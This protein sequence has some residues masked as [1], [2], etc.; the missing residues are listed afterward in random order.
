MD[1]KNIK[2]ISLEELKNQLVEMGEQQYR[3]GQVFRWLYKKGV[4]D[5][6][7]MTDLTPA[8]RGKLAAAFTLAAPAAARTL[9]ADD[10]TEKYLFRLAD[11]A[12]IET[13]FIP[14]RDRNTVCLSTQSGC[15]FGCVFCASGMNGFRRDLSTGE[16]VNQVLYVLF[17]RR[18]TVNN[19]VVMGMGEP[20]D[21]Y[22][23]LV[24][25]L[26]T[27]N[28]PEGLGIGARR[29]T[30]STCGI[31]PGIKNF[32][33]LGLQIELSISLHAAEDELR[34]KLMPVNRKYPL[35]DLLKACREYTE[36]TGR[37]VTFEYVLVRDLN[38]R[39]EHAE[40]LGRAAAT[41]SAKINLIPYSAVPG[42]P[43][44]EPAEE[45]VAAFAAVLERAKIP[46]TVRR[47]RGKRIQAACGQLAG[48]ETPGHE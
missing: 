46:V 26:R 45:T 1:E 48:Q 12:C 14:A 24:A 15:K 29:I 25:A 10:G 17:D 33:T 13:V 18:L 11:G 41:V 23:H 40:A 28:R 5:F 39:P 43:Y 34:S 37:K 35:A 7:R 36:A 32:Q 2:N 21:N 3:A 20:F 27:I 47:S 9:K 19:I 22:D 4:A 44:R 31:I 6:S 42:K 30:V 8:L 38:D 16:I